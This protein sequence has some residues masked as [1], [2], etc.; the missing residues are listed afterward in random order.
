MT[1]VQ[2][3]NCML[4]CMLY[5]YVRQQQKRAGWVQVLAAGGRRTGTGSNLL[6]PSSSATL[7]DAR[8]RTACPQRARP[9]GSRAPWPRTAPASPRPTPS[10]GTVPRYQARRSRIIYRCVCEETQPPFLTRGP[11]PWQCLRPGCPLVT[12]TRASSPQTVS[13]HPRLARRGPWPRFG[14]RLPRA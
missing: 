13:T 1:L 8:R 9:A 12:P 5:E 2:Y 14:T 11:A 3:H 10:G 7:S 6:G 4:Y